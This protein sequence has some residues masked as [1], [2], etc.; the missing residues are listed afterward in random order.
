MSREEKIE[1]KIEEMV[2]Q[3]MISLPENRMLLDSDMNFKIQRFFMTTLND[4][5]NSWKKHAANVYNKLQKNDFITV[6]KEFRSIYSTFSKGLNFD[7][8]RDLKEGKSNDVSSIS[9]GTV[10][11]SNLQ[12]GNNNNQTSSI[13]LNIS[14]LVAQVAKT[15]DQD[16]KRK[17]K[18]LLQ[19]STVGSVIGA[20]VS[21]LLTLL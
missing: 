13:N 8:W 20:G 6:N 19:N 16:A 21:S 5:S 10:N 14:D 2:Y 1:R 12:V 11:A 17:L 18:E 15:D 9:I 7:D 3:E 4:K